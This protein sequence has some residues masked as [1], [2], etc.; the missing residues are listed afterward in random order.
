MTLELINYL[1]YLLLK[2]K[3]KFWLKKLKKEINYEYK[4]LN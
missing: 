2:L 4:K 3:K 1:L